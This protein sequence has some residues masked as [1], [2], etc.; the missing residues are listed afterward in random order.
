[1]ANMSVNQRTQ[2]D[3]VDLS[4]PTTGVR[5]RSRRAVIAYTVLATIFLGVL[6]YAT[7]VALD[8]WAKAVVLGVIILTAVGAMIAVNPLRRG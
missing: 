1:M 7:A 4:V 8:G 2:A 3:R 5:V 6:A